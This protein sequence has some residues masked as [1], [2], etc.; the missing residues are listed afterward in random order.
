MFDQ[1][2]GCAFLVE[3]S[4]HD[5]AIFEYAA[6]RMKFPI[7]LRKHS[8]GSSALAEIN[9]FN[10]L[11]ATQ[12]PALFIL[13]IAIADVDGIALCKRIL[14]IYR[15]RGSEEP[16]IVFLTSRPTGP[17]LAMARMS[18]NIDIHN[19]PTRL[20]DYQQIFQA[21]FALVLNTEAS[22]PLPLAASA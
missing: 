6:R 1:A 21:M 12:L 15:A 7:T 3:D 13:D 18:H 16:K 9:S 11:E 4:E 10:Q 2:V 17:A 19:K 20:A 8:S 5:V 22:V 14:E